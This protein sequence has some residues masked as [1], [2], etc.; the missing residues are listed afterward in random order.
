MQHFP[1]KKLHLLSERAD[2]DDWQGVQFNDPSCHYDPKTY[3]VESQDLNQDPSDF[4]L[5]K[6][7][8]S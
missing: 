8:L 6:M 4:K 2:E 7:V 3:H 1:L 5:I